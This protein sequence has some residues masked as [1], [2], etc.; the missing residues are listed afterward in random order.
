MILAMRRYFGMRFGC[1]R[2]YYVVRG[3]HEFMT[4]G[5]CRAAPRK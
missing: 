4:E 5:W 1:Y 3:A 2:H